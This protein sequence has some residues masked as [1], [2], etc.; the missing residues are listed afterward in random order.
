VK[1]VLS[2]V[3]PHI[4]DV[5]GLQ[6][7][8]VGKQ[9][10]NCRFPRNERLKGRGEIRDVF[11][12]GKGVAFSGAKLFRLPNGLPYNRIAFA[13]PRK[14]GNAV[15]RNSSR[16]V[17]REVYRHLRSNLRTGYDFVL[18][19]YPE[20]S[21]RSPDSAA[22]RPFKPRG[23]SFSYRMDQIKGLFSRSGVLKFSG[24]QE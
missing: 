12:R 18:L 14:F 6:V 21:Q 3:N 7:S 16:R 1:A 10:G 15:M 8:A 2:G 19:I 17:C 13:F 5:A 11:N 22:A 9:S 23:S 4:A 20:G 24:N